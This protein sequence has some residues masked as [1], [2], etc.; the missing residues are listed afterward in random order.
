MLVNIDFN[1][2]NTEYNI[3]II[4]GVDSHFILPQDEWRRDYL[5]RSTSG[6]VYDDE[7]GLYMDYPSGQIIFNRFKHFNCCVLNDIFCKRTVFYHLQ[8][9]KIQINYISKL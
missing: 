5:Q 7:A 4:A 8:G 3:E 9:I 1:K 2:Y 6:I